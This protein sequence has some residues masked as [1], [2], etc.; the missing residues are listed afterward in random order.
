LAPFERS[1]WYTSARNPHMNRTLTGRVEESRS[2]RPCRHCG[3]CG[4]TLHARE[5]SKEGLLHSMRRKTL[6]M[7]YAI[8]ERTSGEAP[9]CP[10]DMDCKRDREYRDSARVTCS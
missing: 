2:C 1:G 9:S 4:A 6:Q 5:R 8:P 7:A 3:A 10:S